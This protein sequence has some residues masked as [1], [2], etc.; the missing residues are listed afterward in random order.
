MQRTILNMYHHI[1]A[2]LT[3]I[4]TIYSQ[5]ITL[6]PIIISYVFHVFGQHVIHIMNKCQCKLLQVCLLLEVIL[7]YNF[8]KS[9]SLSY[10]FLFHI[11][12]IYKSY[13]K[14]KFPTQRSK[15]FQRPKF[16]TL[17]MMK[18]TQPVLTTT[19]P[20]RNLMTWTLAVT[21]QLISNHISTG[22]K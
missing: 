5:M 14:H 4:L 12:Q 10:N 21:H 15:K 3:S 16:L 9:Y 6:L 18:M 11:L 20:R 7:H 13:Q 8:N 2:L 1:T 19:Y 22:N 17:Q